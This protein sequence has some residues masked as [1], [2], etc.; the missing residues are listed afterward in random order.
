MSN[1]ET[2]YKGEGNIWGAN[3]GECSSP[4]LVTVGSSQVYR[5]AGEGWLPVLRKAEAPLTAA[6][7]TQSMLEHL[8]H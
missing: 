2:L 7:E 5:Q 1:H 3:K 4:G 8:I 6:K